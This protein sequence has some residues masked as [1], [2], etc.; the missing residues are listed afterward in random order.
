M[1]PDTWKPNPCGC[2]QCNVCAWYYTHLKPKPPVVPDEPATVK[3]SLPV[4]PT[5]TL[6]DEVPA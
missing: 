3:E 5:P 6:F 2:G 1:T 4:Q